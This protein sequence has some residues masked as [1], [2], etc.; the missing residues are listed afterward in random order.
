M[1]TFLMLAVLLP[2]PEPPMIV[3]ITV[4]KR[5]SVLTGA[6]WAFIPATVDFT[7]TQRCIETSTCHEGTPWLVGSAIQRASVMAAAAGVQ[8]FV[9]YKLRTH[10]HRKLAWFFRILGTAWH[11]TAAFAFR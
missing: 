9:D 6:A 4:E 2:S 3:S 8:T 7:A 11:I 10:G 1:I 5:E